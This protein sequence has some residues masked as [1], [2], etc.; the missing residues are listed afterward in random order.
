M[1]TKTIGYALIMIGLAISLL[2]VGIKLSHDAHIR[3]YVM[4]TGSCFLDDGTCL[5][6]TNEI[7]YFIAGWIMGFSLILLGIFMILSYENYR[8]V[9]KENREV[10]SEIRKVREEE[11]VNKSFESFLKGFSDDEKKVLRIIREQQGIKQNTLRLKAELSKTGL[12][13][14]LQSL[15]GRGI[16]EKKSEGK[17]NR[18]FLKGYFGRE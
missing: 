15:E 5:H 9:D 11:S 1:N 16:I 14:M 2:L 17:T 18:V 6:A 7:Y 10:L 3:V 8:R 12:S 4:E 13:L